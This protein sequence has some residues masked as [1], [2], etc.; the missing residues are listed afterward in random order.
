[1]KDLSVSATCTLSAVCW[2][3]AIGSAV[4]YAIVGTRGLGLASILLAAAG[5]TL[6]VRCY[7]LSLEEAL[8]ARERNAFE[9]GRDA[10]QIRPL[11]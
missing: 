3:S 6:T 11:P 8:L 7:L 5:A 1:M 9:L 4:F 10:R 2:V